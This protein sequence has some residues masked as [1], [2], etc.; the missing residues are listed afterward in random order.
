[1]GIKIIELEDSEGNKVIIN[2]A[3]VCSISEMDNWDKTEGAPEKIV[4]VNCYG[5]SNTINKPISELKR[6]I[7]NC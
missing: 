3:S 4:M 1:M 7:F 6:L 2:P 5:Y